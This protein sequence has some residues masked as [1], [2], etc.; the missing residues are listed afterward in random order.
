[1]LTRLCC[2]IHCWALNALAFPDSPFDAEF[3]LVKE[4]RMT[5]L[6]ATVIFQI[7]VVR[8]LFLS[9]GYVDAS[10]PVAEK[11]LQNGRN[12]FVCTGGEEESMRTVVGK[13]VVVL[14]KRKVSVLARQE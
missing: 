11:V 5:G 12:L 13:D 6:A 14:N 8:E 1:L 2:R 4:G 10:R 7:P 3:G 9:M